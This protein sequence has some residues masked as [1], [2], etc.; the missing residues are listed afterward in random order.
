MSIGCGGS[1]IFDPSGTRSLEETTIV[2]RRGSKSSIK[3]KACIDMIAI[4]LPPRF[5]TCVIIALQGS[6]A[7]HCASQNDTLLKTVSWQLF[8]RASESTVETTLGS[9]N[10][11]QSSS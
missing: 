2:H 4:C 7:S 6:E 9:M 10:E 11:D 8:F 5:S 1:S 3:H